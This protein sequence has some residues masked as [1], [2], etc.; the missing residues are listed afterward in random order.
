MVELPASIFRVDT[1]NRSL[2]KVHS[3][4]TQKKGHNI[5]INICLLVVYFNK[6]LQVH[7]L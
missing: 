7:K 3:V 2:I 5:Q 4:I 1:N 6:A